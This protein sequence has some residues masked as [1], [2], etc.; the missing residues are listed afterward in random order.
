MDSRAQIAQHRCCLLSNGMLYAKTR[1][2][3]FVNYVSCPYVEIIE[4]IGV[5]FIM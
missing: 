1:C 5:I 3:C 4:I 2:V